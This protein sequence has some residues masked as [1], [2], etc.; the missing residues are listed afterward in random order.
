MQFFQSDKKETNNANKFIF[1][2]S[3]IQNHRGRQDIQLSMNLFD[4]THHPDLL[5]IQYWFQLLNYNKES[6]WLDPD[7]SQSL[8]E[9]KKNS[10]PSYQYQIMLKNRIKVFK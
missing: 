7:D 3:V 10:H 1:F 8:Y 4:L 6:Q 2:K 9:I 5:V